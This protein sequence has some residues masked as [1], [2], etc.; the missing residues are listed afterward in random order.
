V[1]ARLLPALDMCGGHGVLDFA[2]N[3]YKFKVRGLSVNDMGVADITAAGEVYNLT[4]LSD[5]EGNYF[6]V[7]AGATIA[8]GGSAAW[9]KNEHGVVIKI[10]STTVGLRFTVSVDGMH[11]KIQKDKV[12]K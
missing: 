4:K 2:N 6:S 10:H 5:F 11:V 3:H 9:L 8:G 12:Q 1:V 7:A